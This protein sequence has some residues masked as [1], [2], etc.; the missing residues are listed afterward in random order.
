[1]RAGSPSGDTGAVRRSVSCFLTA[2]VVD[3]TSLELQVTVAA[4]RTEEL[5]VT[6]DGA[7]VELDEVRTGLGRLHVGR[8]PAGRLE[9]RYRATVEGRTE[10]LLG[11]ALEVSTYL[12]PSRYSESDRLAALAAAHF[13]GLT[14]PAELLPAVSAFVGSR[15]AYVSG[16]SRGTDGAVDTLLAGAGVCRDF[17]HLAVALLRARDVPARLA[18]VYAPGLSPMDF[19]AVVEA[20]VDGVWLVADPTLLAP[21][22]SLLRIAT[23][24]DAADT[25]FLSNYGGEVRLEAVEVLAVVDGELPVDDLGRSV[26]LG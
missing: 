17:A 1:M 24:R 15:L 26:S 4:P 13:A 22:S 3:P 11:D 23:G 8:V 16:S 2:Q 14:D 10:P 7:A 18:A 12:R 20:L 21:R 6:V 5:L 19:H 25:A 9:V